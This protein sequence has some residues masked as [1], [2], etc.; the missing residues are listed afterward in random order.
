MKR[1]LMIL[2]FVWIC[3]KIHKNYKAVGNFKFAGLNVFLTENCL[4]I[5]FEKNETV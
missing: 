2:V 1:A 4:T 3:K 5:N